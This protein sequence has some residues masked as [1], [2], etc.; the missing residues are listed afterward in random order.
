MILYIVVIHS[1]A[2]VGV[3]YFI[4]KDSDFE[5]G[6]DQVIELSASSKINPKGYGGSPFYPHEK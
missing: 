6:E 1:L 4:Q 3:V 2:I 5:L